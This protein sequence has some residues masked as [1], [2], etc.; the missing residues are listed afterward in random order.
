MN[1][2]ITIQKKQA[3]FDTMQV[4]LKFWVMKTTKENVNSQ[5]KNKKSGKVSPFL[6]GL[7]NQY[8]S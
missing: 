7:Y 6:N 3:M 1:T 5:S 8:I 4:K 2:V